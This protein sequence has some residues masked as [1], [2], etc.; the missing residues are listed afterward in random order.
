MTTIMQGDAY[1]IPVT[2]KAADGT[3]IDNTMAETVEVMIGFIRK[4]YPGEITFYDGR[5]LFPLTQEETMK[6]DEHTKSVQ[7]R[8]KF[9]GGDVVGAK[10]GPISIDDSRSKEVL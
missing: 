7:V 6:L 10:C 5:W 1:S 2:I 9:V 8:V 4:T 3:A